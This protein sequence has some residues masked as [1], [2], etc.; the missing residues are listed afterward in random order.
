MD[1]KSWIIVTLCVA[2]MGV[3]WHYMQENQKL[4]Q[5]EAARK[6]QEEIAKK[7]AETPTAPTVAAPANSATSAVPAAPVTA[8]LPEETHSLKVGTVTFELTS[9][10]GGIARAI[11]AGTDQVTLNKNGA[12][13]IGALRREA[14]GMDA[15]SYK[16]TAKSDKGAT[17]EGTTAEGIVV[18]K[19]YSLSEGAEGDEHLIDLKIT[20]KNTG[21]AQHRSEE[22]Y[23][24]AGAASALK[25]DEGRYDGF[26]W[27]NA[28]DTDHEL[29]NYFG[30]G[31]FSDAPDEYR[32]SFNALR[33]AGVMSR[34]YTHI[35][36]RMA[37]KDASGKLWADRRKLAQPLDAANAGK[38]EIEDFAYDAVMGLPVVD[39]APGATVTESYQIY[40]GPKEY[41]RLSKIGHQRSYAMFY[42]Y[43]KIV[44]IALSKVMRW[45]HNISGSWGLAVILLTIFVRLC[46]WPI[47]AKSTMTMK[48]MGLLGP[49]MKELQVKYKDNPQQQQM[50]TMKLYKEYGV[51]PLGG[52]LPLFLQFPIFI[53]LY[54]V[55]EVAAELRGQSF[56]WVRDLAAADTQGYFMG[57]PVNPLPII[58]GLT[59]VAQM[60]LTPQ[61]ATVDKTQQRIF[62]LMPLFF[63]WISYDFAAALAL[64][65]STQNIF[66]VFQ[67]WVM[68]LYM[69]EPKL[70]KA[71][72]KPAAKAAPAQS[73][74]FNAGG[75]Q[76]DKKKG[77]KPPRLGG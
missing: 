46:L 76:K 49:L 17:F 25:H 41:D 14:S 18:T 44:S 1:R 30:K 77:P 42:G 21:T 51:N 26:F 29:S 2:L 37:E 59:M 65:W 53:G 62:M 43:F 73:S 15:T 12:E 55:L 34:F 69:P 64:Y 39:L 36:T 9:K 71:A 23:L 27:N 19:A 45:M 70:E 56:W 60:K 20:L 4:A 61:P 13:A 5:T 58:M 33:Y 28:G 8:A 22:Y 31:V 63:L 50:E 72:L 52:C 7:P 38:A 11:L 47:H 66:S 16:L 32:H 48:R 67:T 57:F 54:S 3:N 35:I 40:L 74:F 24:Y 75:D 10:G 68:K 6:K